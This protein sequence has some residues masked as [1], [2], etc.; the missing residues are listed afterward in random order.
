MELII[1]L[2]AI[3]VL[4]IGA[5][6]AAGA[7]GGMQPEPV[8]DHETM[9][10]PPSPLTGDDLRG[11]RFDVTPRGYNMAEVDALLH[12]LA[13]EADGTSY[14]P[15]E[16]TRPTPAKSKDDK[17]IR[18]E[19]DESVGHGE[20]T[21]GS[22]T[23]TGRTASRSSESVTT[24]AARWR[25]KDDTAEADESFWAEDSGDGTASPRD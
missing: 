18:E 14:G 15:S 1:V 10:L 6:V 3:V 2:V 20:A 17:V 19:L 4:G 9:V 16:G 7:F 11:L 21:S 12:R 23:E 25:G 22:A 13:D 5:M 24:R 8:R